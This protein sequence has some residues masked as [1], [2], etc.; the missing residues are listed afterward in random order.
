LAATS[1]QLLCSPPIGFIDKGGGASYFRAMR[2]H[3]DGEPVQ[4]LSAAMVLAVSRGFSARRAA[5]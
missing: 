5:S 3:G 1:P 4:G 2:R